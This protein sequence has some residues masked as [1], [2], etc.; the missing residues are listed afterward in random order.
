MGPGGGL[1]ALLGLGQAEPTRGE[2]LALKYERR[3]ERAIA[4]GNYGEAREIIRSIT[5]KLIEAAESFSAGGDVVVFLHRYEQGYKVVPYAADLPRGRA[6][7]ASQEVA[8]ALRM[9]SNSRI[10]MLSK[11][12]DAWA[13]KLKSGL[14]QDA[15]TAYLHP[16]ATVRINSQSRFALPQSRFNQP[17]AGA[18]GPFGKP[19]SLIDFQKNLVG[20]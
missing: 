2:K 16:N 1:T 5:D 12:I 3:M 14:P 8:A 4:A 10:A 19:A 11:V 13:V 7:T 9:A 20:D 18:W 15:K 6:A 17:A